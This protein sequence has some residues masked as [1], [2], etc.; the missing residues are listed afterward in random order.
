M[1]RT[2]GPLVFARIIDGVRRKFMQ[3]ALLVERISS[4]ERDSR[5]LAKSRTGREFHFRESREPS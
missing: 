4:F 5:D 2:I 1:N 3:N